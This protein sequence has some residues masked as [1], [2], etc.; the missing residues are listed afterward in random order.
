MA[1]EHWGSRLT[2]V[3]AAA[4]SAVGLG[5]IWKFPYLAGKN[6]GGAFL[7]LYLACLALVGIPLMLCELVVGRS[8]QR[9]VVGAFRNLAPGTRWYLVGFM[10][11][12]AGFLI[13]SFYSVVAGW[14]L[15]YLY[16]TVAGTYF[17]HDAAQIQEGFSAFIADYHRPLLW[18]FVF[19][20]L[21]LAVVA[22]GVKD[23]IE[24]WSKILMPVLFVLI[25]VV[26][27]TAASLPGA[28]GGYTFLFSVDW[29]RIMSARVVL[30]AMGQAFF[31]LSLGMGAMITYGSY[32][33]RD[34]SLPRSA[35][36]VVA[37]DTA[38]A[39]MAGLAIFPAVFAFGLEPAQGPGLV[40]CTL[41]TIF[42][43]MAWGRVVGSV[44]FV[45]LVIAALTSAISLLE[46]VVAYFVEEYGWSRLR[47]TVGAAAVIAVLGV[48]S[49]L[50]F[51]PATGA[52]PLG[53]KALA[54]P[55]PGGTF[56]F[57]DLVDHVASNLLLPLGGLFICLFVGWSWGTRR[58]LG[59]AGAGEP[60]FDT[61]RAGRSWLFLVRFVAPL[62][63]TL[64]F[65]YSFKVIGFD[66]AGGLVFFRGWF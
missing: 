20:G 38:V 62:V 18:H 13:L 36:W 32:L 4:G 26:I 23:G 63:V 5:N 40:F 12:A 54:I 11:L 27:V 43:Q 25:L 17:G 16:Q 59:E 35:L 9:N 58:A 15:E 66:E 34:E 52:C 29:S 65:L 28:W 24:F 45:S 56:S 46:V 1:R 10:G 3:L 6:G 22:G 19:M 44:F 37:A 60:G 55:F 39:V 30:E 42:T 53:I 48:P 61:G 57:F 14:S 8:A 47:T 2:F 64:V 41:P 50:S 21:T 33:G 31:S 7:V 49:A 51:C